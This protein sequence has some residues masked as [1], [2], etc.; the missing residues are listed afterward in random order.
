MVLR[1]AGPDA[2]PGP[3]RRAV[4]PSG[5][6]TTPSTAV[7]APRRARRPARLSRGSRSAARPGHE[8]PAHPRWTGRAGPAPRPHRRDAAVPGLDREAAD[9]ACHEIALQPREKLLLR[10]YTHLLPNLQAA[11]AAAGTLWEALIE[12]HHD[13]AANRWRLQLDDAGLAGLAHAVH[14]EALAGQVAPRNRL[15]RAH[16]LTHPH[17]SPPP[18]LLVRNAVTSAGVR[19]LV[20]EG[21]MVWPCPARRGWIW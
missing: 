2:Q 18:P 1:R 10:R 17:P 12:T 5:R 3:A 11:P 19:N 7:A 16:D 6:S 15:H 20:V 9:S 21:G 13:P 8:P 4:T 14:L